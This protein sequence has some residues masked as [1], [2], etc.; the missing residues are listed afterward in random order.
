MSRPGS[1]SDTYAALLT[2]AGAGAIACLALHGPKAWEVVRSLFRPR[3]AAG[4]P[5]PEQP[6]VGPL[7]LGLLGAPAADEVVITI[8]QTA[9]ALV[10]VHCHGGR[11]VV[12]MLQELFATR[13]VPSCSWQEFL[14]RTAGNALQAAAA[15]CLA[16]ALTVR[17]AAILLDQYQGA[18]SNARERIFKHWDQGASD[19]AAESLA[20]MKRICSIG[21]HLTKP[22]RVVLAGAPNVGKSSLA[23]ALAGY[24]RCIVTE[25]P[26]T[27]RD[28]VTTLIAVDGW[29]VQLADTAGLRAGGTDLE[30]QGMSLSRDA[31][32]QADLCLWL[33]DA[34]REPVWPDFQ[35]ERICFVINKIDLAPA[36]SLQ[37]VTNAAHVCARTGEGLQGLCETI[38]HA[39]VPNSPGP[40]AAVPFTPR[41]CDAVDRAWQLQS[42]GQWEQ[43]QRALANACLEPDNSLSEKSHERSPLA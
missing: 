19:D 3:S 8:K 20:K 27:T 34:S 13:G 15:M 43:A 23:N 24:E 14:R 7:W 16:N 9:P 28:V 18:F 39:V 22:Y 36:W 42:A 21:R 37:E 10:E 29:P 33:L 11:E 6:E 38:S 41:L 17:T 2:P 32:S 12:R 31:A 1:T 5:L 40:G 4:S 26:G 25:T 30:A 35:L